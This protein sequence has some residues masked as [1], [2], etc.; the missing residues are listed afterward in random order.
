MFLFILYAFIAAVPLGY[1]YVKHKFKYFE[2]RNVL[3]VTPTSIMGNLNGVGTKIHV[4][5][6]LGELYEKFKGKAP[7]IGMYWLTTP[8]FIVTDLNLCRNILIRDF[9]SFHDRGV[10]VNEVEDPLSGHLFSLS[11][12]KWKKMRTKLTPT[13]TS[14]K[15][16][17]MY[18]TVTGVSN[19][20]MDYVQRISRSNEPI[21]AKKMCLRY[22]ADVIGSCAFGLK[23][24]ALKEDDSKIIKIAEDIFSPAGFQSV[25]L[26][27]IN[28]FQSLS[29]KMGVRI[30]PK[31]VTEFFM[32][33]IQQTV[34][35][36]EQYN[37]KRNDFIEILIQI[38]NS[39]TVAAD[40]EGEQNDVGKITFDE[41]AAQAFV[42]FFAGFE[43]SSTTMNFCL[44]ELARNTDVQE[45]VRQDVSNVLAKHDGKL[46]YEAINEMT[47]LDQVLNGSFI[48]TFRL[49]A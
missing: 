10:Y 23:C 29:K 1:L 14:G 9:N 5:D 24:N 47:Y 8:T 21:D 11:G 28:S 7:I 3:H 49:A 27:F 44:F 26:L 31:N 32:D 12:L 17:Q 34:N 46:T 39:G 38:K 2:V 15:I 20:F 16:K 37:E 22:T 18:S 41:L 33:M 4:T 35:H 30:F 25:K 43:T 19:D 36:R 45:K 48:V 6:R 42:F 40:G 13:F